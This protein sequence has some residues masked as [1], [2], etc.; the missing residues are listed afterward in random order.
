MAKYIFDIYLQ[1]FSYYQRESYPSALSLPCIQW[2]WFSVDGPWG[3]LGKDVSDMLGFHIAIDTSIS[4]LT[5]WATY[6]KCLNIIRFHNQDGRQHPFR[7][8]RVAHFQ[9]FDKIPVCRRRRPT[10]PVLRKLFGSPTLTGLTLHL[11]ST[12]FWWRGVHF[13]LITGLAVR[14]NW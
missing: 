6:A 7:M 12:P 10:S 8:S 1:R 2:H 14:A 5:T 3:I 11:H 4:Q 9:H 13:G